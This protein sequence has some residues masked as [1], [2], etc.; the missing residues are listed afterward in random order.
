MILGGIVEI[1]FGANSEGQAL[2]SVAEPLSSVSDRS[3]PHHH[4]LRG[5]LQQASSG[6]ARER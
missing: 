4:E 1:L 2:E 5:H 3:Q 6:K